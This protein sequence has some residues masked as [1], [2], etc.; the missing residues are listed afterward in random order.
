M[1][2]IQVQMNGYAGYKRFIK[3]HDFIATTGNIQQES[4]VASVRMVLET[5]F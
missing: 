3:R 2:I 5:P 1:C 4:G